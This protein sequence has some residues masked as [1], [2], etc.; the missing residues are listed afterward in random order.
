MAGWKR[1]LKKPTR[2]VQLD[3]TEQ[4]IKSSEM[5]C[6]GSECQSAA[7]C[8]DSDIGQPL[9]VP[10]SPPKLVGMVSGRGCLQN[11]NLGLGQHRFTDMTSSI[12]GRWLQ[13]I[14]HGS[15]RR[16]FLRHI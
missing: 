10:G 5:N 16:S 1:D 7:K 2:T 15:F 8:D 14:K 11:T 9:V 6:D 12:Y 4:V 3:S 13:E